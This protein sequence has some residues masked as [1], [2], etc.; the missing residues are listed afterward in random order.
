MNLAARDIM[1]APVITCS[2]E[3]SVQDALALMREKG[4]SG[5]PAVDGD[6][7]A[8]GIVSQND[9]LKG[10]AFAH[11]PTDF[12][13]SFKADRRKASTVMLE[14]VLEQ[15]RALAVERYLSRPIADVMTRDLIACTP[16]TALADVCAAAAKQR[17]HR[18]VVLDPDGKVV[19]IISTLDLVA[20]VAEV[21]GRI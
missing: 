8:V 20:K 17:V 16:A 2:Q 5:L 9:I 7:R 12:L 6:G 4:I 3:T 21:A 15:G 1:T 18:I 13:E 10:I 11:G 14:M 19:G